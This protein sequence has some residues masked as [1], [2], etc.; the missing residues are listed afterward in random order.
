MDDIVAEIGVEAMDNDSP[1]VGTSNDNDNDDND[2][3]NGDDNMMTVTTTTTMTS[4]VVIRKVRRFG[5][6]ECSN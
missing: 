5:G 3:G 2:D 4:V 1:D 6:G